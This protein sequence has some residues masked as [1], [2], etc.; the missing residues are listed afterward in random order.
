MNVHVPQS[1]NQVLPR[2]VHLDSA[3]FPLGQR[4]VADYAEV[5]AALAEEIVKKV[6]GEK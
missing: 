4:G 5:P 1:G 3:L 6:R 2:A